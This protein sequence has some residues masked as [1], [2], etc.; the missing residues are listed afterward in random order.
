MSENNNE[1]GT[2]KD[3]DYEIIEQLKKIV[4]MAFSEDELDCKKLKE[5]LGQTEISDS[6]EKY[7]FTW[8]GKKQSFELIRETTTK[9]LKPIREESVN[10]DESENLFIEGDNLDALKILQKAYYEQ[11]KMIYIDPPFNTGK[12]FVYKDDFKEEKREYEEKTG[13][14][15][16]EG[17][18]VSNPETSGR[19][20]SD[21]LTMMY[22]RLFLARN[23][24]KKEGV[25]FVSIDDNEVHN[26]RMIMN[27][28]F[29]EENF[30]GQFIWRNKAGGGGKQGHNIKSKGYKK[31]E[32]FVIDHE[33]IMVYA[34]DINEITRFN[35]KLSEKE[36]SKYKN[37]DDDP[38]GS[39]KL[40]ALE[41]S[42]PTEISTMYYPLKDPDGKEVR[43][44]G[45]RFQWRFSEERAK[46]EIEEGKI[47]W[48][49][50]S[51]DKE[52]D[53]RGYY[54]KPMVK[55][56]LKIQGEERTQSARSILYDIAYTRNGTKEIKN[57]FDTEN[58][59]VFENPKPID[60][61]RHILEM[62]TEENDII[63]DFFAGSGSLADAVLRHS[64]QETPLNFI[65][66]QLAEKVEEDSGA[67]KEGFKTVSEIAKKRITKV[68][69]EL[70]GGEG[71]EDGIEKGQELGFKSFKL[72]ESNFV[73]WNP[74]KN[75]EEL[76]KQLKLQVKSLR[77]DASDDN[78]IFE[79]LLK[80]GFT[81]NAN[82]IEVKSQGKVF[83]EISEEDSVMYFSLEDN[84]EENDLKDLSASKETTIII[85]DSSLS[86]TAKDNISRICN[87]KTV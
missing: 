25:I 12:N 4:P 21:W 14:R 68:I 1:I 51:C 30:V 87:L 26:L 83:Y 40:K 23:L 38:R 66:V 45:G 28:I 85:L 8:A 7:N 2:S 77:E 71:K 55:Q 84:I 56:Y 76:K 32:A 60:L 82:I 72:Q 43:P 48:K 64:K 22:P 78:I 20:H 36:L 19:Y 18:L 13:Q 69:K 62:Y 15:S 10:F 6:S 35:K 5:L 58:F 47:I 65:C 80:E 70:N 33:Y 46:K 9:T 54:Y 49:K 74:P 17:K 81:P 3:I 37:P 34:K 31:K 86:D 67:A 50:I 24:L 53:E 11:V 79:I 16:E 27:E 29:G 57:L 41:Q 44:K 42:I 75:D 61:L 63:L 52:K 39:Y 73:E 59:V